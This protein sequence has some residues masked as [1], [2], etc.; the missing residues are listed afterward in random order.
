MP[1]RR[2]RQ[3]HPPHS[4]PTARRD[5]G[6][7]VRPVLLLCAGL[8]GLLG[9]AALSIPTVASPAAVGPPRALTRTAPASDRFPT[10]GV[11]LSP[12]NPVAAIRKMAWARQQE[13][14]FYNTL[15][16]DAVV[17]RNLEFDAAVSHFLQ[18]QAQL[19]AF[20]AA[21]AAAAAA[22]TAAAVDPLSAAPASVQATFA[23]IRQVESHD[24][25][26]AVNPSSGAGGAYQ[27]LPST[28]WSLGGSGL[29]EDAPPAVQDAMALKAYDLEGWSPWAGDSCV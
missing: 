26:S 19:R 17:R 1:T 10:T 14:R 8:A 18:A 28:W 21:Q 6:P 3:A 24:N 9:L 12:A 2:S 22:R 25:Y 5:G 23:C 11:G 7:R 4:A 15:A 27:F 16:W 29:P 20:A 13:Q